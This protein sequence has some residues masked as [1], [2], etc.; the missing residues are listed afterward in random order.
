MQQ[1][2]CQKRVGDR[3]FEHK[4]VYKRFKPSHERS[5]AQTPAFRHATPWCIGALEVCM[6]RTHGC[7]F[8]PPRTLMDNPDAVPFSGSIEARSLSDLGIMA[9]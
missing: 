5:L 2:R 4:A 6:K 1:D 8:F 9:G 7:R 3:F